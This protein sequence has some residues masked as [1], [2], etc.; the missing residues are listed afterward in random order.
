MR[1]DER[2]RAGS[3][4]TVKGTSAIVMLRGR[5][6]G[7]ASR[8]PATT[9]MNSLV[10]GELRNGESAQERECSGRRELV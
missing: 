3:G 7:G 10:D 4:S 5:S 1:R 6:S 2:Q 9:V 8:T